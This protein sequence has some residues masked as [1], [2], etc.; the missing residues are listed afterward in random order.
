MRRIGFLALIATALLLLVGG[1]KGEIAKSETFALQKVQKQT[2]FPEGYPQE[3]TLP[4][5]FTPKD[6]STSK[7]TSTGGGK[8]KREYK[9]YGLNK[10][11]NQCP[12]NILDHYKQIVEKNGWKGKWDLYDGGGSGIFTKSNM[13]MEV[14]IDDMVFNFKVK[15]YKE[16]PI[17]SK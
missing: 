11:R 15:V 4:D 8:G 17:P 12:A 6:I 2:A 14:K 1:Q 5:G 7:G 3:L 9:S 13:E 16:L 10:M